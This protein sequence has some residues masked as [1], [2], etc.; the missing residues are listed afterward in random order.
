MHK[1]I[2]KI[3]FF[4]CVAVSSSAQDKSQMTDSSANSIVNQV[5]KDRKV[6]NSQSTEMLNAGRLDF[7]VSH[8]FGD[9]AGEGGGWSSFYGL[10]SA[11]DIAIGFDYGISDNILIGINR[12]KGAGPL[13]QNL[14]GHLKIRFLS[15]KENGSPLSVVAFLNGSYTTMEKG[16]FA[17]SVTYFEKLL[18]RFSYH[19]DLILSSKI[20]KSFSI[21]ALGGYTYRNLVEGDDTNGLISAG[22][23]TRIQLTKALGLIMDSRVIISDIR[24][25]LKYFPVGAGLEWETGGGHV[26]QL[27]VTNARG[28]AETDYIPYTNDDWSAGEF[29]IGFT[30]SRQFS[31]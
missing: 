16:G 9:I 19:S 23:A 29:R 13:K 12:A 21:Q 27:N 14:N 25:D 18:H 24:Q 17:G 8:R 11:R 10:E 20:G 1:I 31:L 6:I 4:I 5:F 26:F 15:Q 7:R 2:F 3:S 22:L 28:I 30:I